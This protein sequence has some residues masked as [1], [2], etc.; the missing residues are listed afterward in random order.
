M[1]FLFVFVFLIGF[2]VWIDYCVAVAVWSFPL[3]RLGFSDFVSRIIFILV[4][5]SCICDLLIDSVLMLYKVHQHHC[6]CIAF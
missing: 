4:C 3:E 2:F 6:M 1:W 5:L